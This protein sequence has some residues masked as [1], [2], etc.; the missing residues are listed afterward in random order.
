MLEFT[1]QLHLRRGGIKDYAALAEHHY[2]AAEP[3][4]AT[5]VLVLE[6]DAPS[7]VGR[8]LGRRG[9][10][11]VVGVLV[12]SLPALNCK[13]RGEAMGER[14]G[15]WLSP[16][17]R[18]AL[19]NAEVRCISRVVIEPTWRGLGLAV[20]LV[21]AALEEPTTPVTEALAAMGQVSPFFEKA[22]MTA[23]P[24]PPHAH[25]QRLLDAL[26]SIG[27]RGLDLA[28]PEAMLRRIEALP[29]AQRA[30]LHHELQRWTRRQ[31]QRADTLGEQLDL[32]QQ[33]LMFNPVYYIQCHE[34]TAG[35]PAR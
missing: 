5:R 34:E 9:E 3:A 32:A 29:D 22:G 18:A 2:R 21:R 13:M 30:F 26:T 24:R 28:L 17:Q 6:Y 12:E 33:R 1:E 14:Y 10:R 31:R 8:F 11:Q 15:S 7:V 19:L 16:T 27:F 4:T 20:R 35:R 23:Y 25:D